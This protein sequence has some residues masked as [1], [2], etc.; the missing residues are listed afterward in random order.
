MLNI[1]PVNRVGNQGAASSGKDAHLERPTSRWGTKTHS[2]APTGVLGTWEG[3]AP[4]FPKKARED[5]D[6]PQLHLL[7]WIFV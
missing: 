7:A 2:E 5:A 1:C 4:A 3:P 6:G